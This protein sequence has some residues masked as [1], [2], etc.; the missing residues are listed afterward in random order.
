MEIRIVALL[1]L[2]LTSCLAKSKSVTLSNG[3]PALRIE[4]NYDF[5]NCERKARQ[6][7]DGSYERIGAGDLSCKDC[8]WDPPAPYP[9]AEGNNVYKGTLYV[10]CK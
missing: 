3:L 8:G 10:R 5:A 6:V 1:A 2:G 7:C 9:P 4:C